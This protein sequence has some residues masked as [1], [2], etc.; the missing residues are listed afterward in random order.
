[1]TTG[2]SAASMMLRYGYVNAK[3]AIDTVVLMPVD[4]VKKRDM[5]ARI[6]R[7]AKALKGRGYELLEG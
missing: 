2:A 5:R 6:M 1:M 3:E 7:W 4:D